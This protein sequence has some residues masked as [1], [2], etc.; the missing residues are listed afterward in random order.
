MELDNFEQ[1][2]E[3]ID[4]SYLRGRHISIEQ[5]LHIEKFTERSELLIYAHR[6]SIGVGRKTVKE[7]QILFIPQGSSVT[8]K[9]GSGRRKRIQEANR[10]IFKDRYFRKS[11]FKSTHPSFTFITFEAKLF[12]SFNFFDSIDAEPFI[13]E[14]DKKI[15][16]LIQGVIHERTTEAPG[17][18]KALNIRTQM[19]LLEVM[20][21]MY[22]N[23]LF[24]QKI[25]N[26]RAY[27]S[28]S[29][30]LTVFQYIK[31]NLKNDLSNRKLADVT[32]VSEEYFGQL[33]KRIT[34]INSQEF[35]ENQRL[36]KAIVLLRDTSKSINEIAGEVGYPDTPY[37]CRRFKKRFQISANSM[38]KR[39]ADEVLK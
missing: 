5:P 17:F 31:E 9:F 6:G 38:R 21:F 3:S 30:L 4:A 36:E 33:F 1:F 14:K 2:I 10:S 18:R 16:K 29:R 15:V 13:I 39:E 8:I 35:V 28:D 23:N 20:R 26:Q 7:G 32:N 12:G 25:T 11:I 24:Q 19:I 34:G 27:F 37:F 22:I